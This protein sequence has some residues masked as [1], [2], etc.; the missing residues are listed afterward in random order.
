MQPM[1]HI[2]E[3]KVQGA[4]PIG[5]TANFQAGHPEMHRLASGYGE[6]G[7]NDSDQGPMPPKPLPAQPAP[8][9]NAGNL[10]AEGYQLP[11]QQQAGS[12]I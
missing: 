5:P 2:P 9:P 4:E 6:H 3:P 1:P 10:L 8:N 12:S 7:G 11:A